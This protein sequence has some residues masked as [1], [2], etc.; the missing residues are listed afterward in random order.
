MVIKSILYGCSSLR[1]AVKRIYALAATLVVSLILA[2]TKRKRNNTL[3]EGHLYK[4]GRVKY[5]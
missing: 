1:A 3:H 5:R 4:D 2:R